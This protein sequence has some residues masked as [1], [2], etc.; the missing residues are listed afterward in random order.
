MQSSAS[1][2]WARP[3]PR[4]LPGAASRCPSPPR[5]TRRRFAPAAAALGPEVMPKTLAEAV[6]ANVI[7]LAVRYEAHA[8]VARALPTWKGKNYRRRDQCLRH[9]VGQVGGTAVRQGRRAGLRRRAT[10]ER[11]Q[12]PGGLRLRPRPASPRRQEGRVPDERRRRR[13]SRG[14]D[15][16]GTARPLP[17]NLGGLAE[18]GL[19]VQA[20]DST[21]GR[22]FPGS[23]QARLIGADPGRGAAGAGAL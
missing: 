17:V 13:H 8:D 22:H 9:T 2:R 4:C 16:R 3:S 5:T 7:F 19:L 12:P 6:Q 18:G 15:A 1:A 11:L 10:G 20:H 23:D 21:W 14:R